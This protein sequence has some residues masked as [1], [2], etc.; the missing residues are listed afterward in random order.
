[1]TDQPYIPT[2]EEIA[3]GTAAARTAWSERERRSRAPWAYADVLPF[4]ERVVPDDVGMSYGTAPSPGLKR[5]EVR[6]D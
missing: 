4:D 2:P 1:M 5:G 6:E 3:A